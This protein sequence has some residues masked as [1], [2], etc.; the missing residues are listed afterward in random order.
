MRL[1][2]RHYCSFL[3]LAFGFLILHYG[4]VQAVFL[5]AMAAAG[6]FVGR[7]LEGEIDLSEFARRREREEPE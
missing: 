6:W 1:S 2:P 7:V 4:F 5:A 3:G